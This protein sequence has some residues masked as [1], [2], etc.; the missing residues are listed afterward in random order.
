MQD[1][2]G[3]RRPALS[4][5]IVTWNGKAY[6]EACLESLSAQRRSPETEVIVVD[7][8]SSDGTPE[9]ILSRFPDVHLIRNEKNLGF[10]RANNIGIRLSR[11]PQIAL[12]NSDVTVPPECLPAMS[13]YVSQHPDVGMIGPR[14]FGPDGLVGRSCMRFP[15]LWVYLSYSLGLD[16]LFRDRPPF[17]GFLM[18]CFTW[19]RTSEVD[20]LN[21][22]FLMIRRD[23]LDKV[24]LLD[25][26]F[27]M[28]GED[29]D[30]SYR[31]FQAGWKRVY[32][33]GAHAVHYG[34][35]SSSLQ[36]TRFYLEMMRAN[37]QFWRKYHSSGA[38]LAYAGAVVVHEA[39]RLIAYSIEFVFSR[40][41]RLD[42]GF[43]IRRSLACLRWLAGEGKTAVVPPR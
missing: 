8:A 11:A 34:G 24:G 28:Y 12:I 41:R 37:L 19:D 6:I 1:L 13:A 22:W 9:L 18:R 2:T 29:L 30:W 4:I 32:F 39:V 3:G 36:P 17:T 42:S 38:A 27:F 40:R 7:N 31:F 35:G 43:K 20:V 33:A 14:M 21:G 5:V 15:T 25:E 26:R 16:L 10:A 23:A